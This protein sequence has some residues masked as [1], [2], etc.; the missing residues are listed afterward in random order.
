[1]SEIRSELRRLRDN[2]RSETCR[3]RVPDHADFVDCG[4]RV[5]E[6][7]ETL[8]LLQTESG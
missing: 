1:M 7:D 3:E 8:S 2:A 4:D 5:A 6:I